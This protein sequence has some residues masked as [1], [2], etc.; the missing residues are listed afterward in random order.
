MRQEQCNISNRSV[1]GS[2]KVL[3]KE[4]IDSNL[5]HLIWCVPDHSQNVSTLSRMPQQGEGMRFQTDSSL[6]T[7]VSSTVGQFANSFDVTPASFTA[8]NT[9]HYS[10][11]YSRDGSLGSSSVA[12][13]PIVS[14]VAH[15]WVAAESQS[16]YSGSPFMFHET[17]YFDPSYTFR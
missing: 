16:A 12:D 6:S 9:P 3:K 14:D 8:P 11:A 15:S 13:Y 17:G 1:S 4:E 7:P 10:P 2:P 5:T